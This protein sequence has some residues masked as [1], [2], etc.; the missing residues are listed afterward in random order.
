M[1]FGDYERVAG[2]YFP[3]SIASGPRNSPD[4]RI[5]TIE[6][7]EVNVDVSPEI[8]AMPAQLAKL[9]GPN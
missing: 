8:F 6:T 4:K 2:V 1:D 5:I 9:S 3:F 7:A